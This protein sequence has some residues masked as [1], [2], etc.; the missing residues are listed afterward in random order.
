MVGENDFFVRRAHGDV[1]DDA[2]PGFDLLLPELIIPIGQLFHDLGMLGI[3]IV[4]L[5]GI[6][7]D[8]VEFAVV[9]ESPALG[10]H[11]GGFPFGDGTPVLLI[12][13]EN[14]LGPLGGVASFEKWSQAFA[15]EGKIARRFEAAEIDQGGRNV[16]DAGQSLDAPFLSRPPAGQSRKN[17]TR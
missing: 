6:G 13:H 12:G 9:D 7:L 11:R 16:G 3:D 14:A 8:V 5:A 4:L 17:G 10:H 1:G 2:D 15:V